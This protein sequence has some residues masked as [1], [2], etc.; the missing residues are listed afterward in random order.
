MERDKYKKEGERLKERRKK[1]RRIKNERKC[2]QADEIKKYEKVTSG[3]T[4]LGKKHHMFSFLARF[5]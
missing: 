3:E 1:E 5:F 4:F 2:N